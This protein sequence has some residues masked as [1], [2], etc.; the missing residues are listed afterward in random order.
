M[1]PKELYKQLLQMINTDPEKLDLFFKNMMESNYD[2]E[3]YWKH[4]L[5]NTTLSDAFIK[6]H[7]DCINLGYLF[8]YQPL[9]DE[10]LEW[11]RSNTTLMPQDL[12]SMVIHQRLS[13]DMI[14]YYID[15]MYPI[16]WRALVTNQ[17]LPIET[18]EKYHENMD[19]DD[20]S[21]EQ[22]LTLELIEKFADKI[23]WRDLPLNMKTQYLF[24]DEFVGH[25]D[26]YIVWDNIGIMDRVTIGCILRNK[27]KLNE[28]AWLSVLLYKEVP[29]EN[30]ESVI[31][32]ASKFVH[33]EQLWQ[34]V[35][36][37]QKLSKDFI[38]RHAGDLDWEAVSGNQDLDWGMLQQYHERVS[39]Y[40]FSRNDCITKELIQKIEENDSLFNDILDRDLIKTFIG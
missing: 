25:F 28:D 34:V 26:G 22:F 15:N 11:L 18:I 2:M 5:E 17:D 35:S 24:N 37:N 7:T 19:W 14:H 38:E 16:N 39:L 30:I 12:E 20:L 6:K 33:G 10:M 31:D 29:E 13:A 9:S 1:T 27:D 36:S 40:H 4:I 21:V 23:N 8:K 3:E 32:A